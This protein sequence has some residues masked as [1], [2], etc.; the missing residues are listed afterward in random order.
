MNETK[1]FQMGGASRALTLRDKIH[2][3]LI[4]PQNPPIGEIIPIL[5]IEGRPSKLVTKSPGKP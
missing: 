4:Q 5:K 2:P 3:D 1:R